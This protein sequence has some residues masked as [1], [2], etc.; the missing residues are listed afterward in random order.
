MHHGGICV[1]IKDNV[2]KVEIS[3]EINTVT[4]ICNGKKIGCKFRK[5]CFYKLNIIHKYMDKQK[6]KTIYEKTSM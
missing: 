3:D 1:E 6:F 2:L 5:P 4:V